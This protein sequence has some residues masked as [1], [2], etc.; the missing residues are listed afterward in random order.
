LG[1]VG[2][3]GTSAQTDSSFLARSDLFVFRI[4]SCQNRKQK[5]IRSSSVY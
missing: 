2:R 4:L 3:V 5:F 1:T